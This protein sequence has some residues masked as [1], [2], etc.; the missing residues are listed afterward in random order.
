[1]PKL[2]LAVCA[3]LIAGFV[4]AGLR[5]IVYSSLITGSG[6]AAKSATHYHK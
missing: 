5:G 1:M 2:Y 4:Y 3:V 6:T